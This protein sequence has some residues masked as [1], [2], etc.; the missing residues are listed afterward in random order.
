MSLLNVEDSCLG[1]DGAYLSHYSHDGQTL[2]IA[3]NQ[4]TPSHG[5]ILFTSPCNDIVIVSSINPCVTPLTNGLNN[6]RYGNL[7]YICL[8]SHLKIIM[9]VHNITPLLIRNDYCRLI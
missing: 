9:F 5:Y 8:Q 7:L 3:V 6:E 2:A 1:T 4:P